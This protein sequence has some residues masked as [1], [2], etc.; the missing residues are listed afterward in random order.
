LKIYVIVEDR[1]AVEVVK[2]IARELATTSKIVVRSIPICSNKMSKIARAALKE[3]DKVVILVDSEGRNPREVERRIE[4]KHLAE[5]AGKSVVIVVDPC[6]E[7]WPCRILELSNCSVAPCSLGPAKSLNEYW[8][9]K[10]RR[11][12]AKRD[13]PAAVKEALSTVHRSTKALEKL[14]E[15]LRKLIDELR[16]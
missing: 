13:L 15:S 14:P 5:G 4:E 9:K 2:L 16:S 3:F 7:A 11:D 1:Y 8:R 6:L 10:H 12:Y